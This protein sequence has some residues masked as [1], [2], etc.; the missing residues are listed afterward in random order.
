MQQWP[1]INNS[2]KSVGWDSLPRVPIAGHAGFVFITDGYTN[3]NIYY[4]ILVKTTDFV[5]FFFFYYV[6]SFVDEI[7]QKG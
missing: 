6:G 7:L 1:V 4:K 3:G 2:P 5:F